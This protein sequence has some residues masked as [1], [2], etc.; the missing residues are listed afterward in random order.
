MFQLQVYILLKPNSLGIN[1]LIEISR[2]FVKF[3]LKSTKLDHFL[4]IFYWH[5]FI[6]NYFGFSSSNQKKIRIKLN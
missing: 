4:D 2:I 5:S 3:D 1:K 6:R